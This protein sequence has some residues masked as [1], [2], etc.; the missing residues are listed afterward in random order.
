MCCNLPA[1]SLPLGRSSVLF[2]HGSSLR[3][4]SSLREEMRAVLV[5]DPMHWE[6]VNAFNQAATTPTHHLSVGGV[7]ERPVRCLGV[8][9][10]ALAL[11]VLFCVNTGF[12]RSADTIKVTLLGTGTPYPSTERYGAAIL[13][14]AGGKKLLFDCGRGAVIRLSQ[15]DLKPSEIDAVFLTHLH[16]DHVV[17]L[18]DLWLTGWFLG[19]ENAFELFGPSGTQAMAKHLT[20]AFARDIAAREAAPENLPRAGVQLAA[21]DIEQGIAYDEGGIRV[22][23]FL[24]DHGNIKAFGYRVDYARHT[25]V[26]SGDT[27][28]S[29]NLIHF[30]RGADCVMHV[31]WSV[32]AANPTPSARR[33]LASAEDAG[34]LFAQVEPK[35]AVV[36]HYKVVTG[37]AETIRTEYPGPL[38][39]AKDLMVIEVGSQVTWHADNSAKIRK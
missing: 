27:K 17:G 32:G 30:A 20:E 25:V 21:K 34:R 4:L 6:E 7:T 12:A 9:I 37:L 15:V 36:Y 31:A 26:I 28:F 3:R 22:T 35:L 38:V 5:L 13:V 2:R 1:R 39:V 23:A 18:P 11:C 10:G 24:V 33:T 8:W 14:E 16:S 29:E 19:R